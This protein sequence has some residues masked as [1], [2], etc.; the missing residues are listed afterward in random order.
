MN[1]ESYEVREWHYDP[2]SITYRGR[3]V[4]NWFSNMQSVSIKG[5]DGLTYPSVEHY[6]Q[7]HKTLDMSLRKS[8]IS[9][10]PY[11]VKR[12]AKT[13]DSFPPDWNDGIDTMWD[14]LNIKWNIPRWN[15]L[16]HSH[17]EIIVEWNNWR[18]SKWGVPIPPNYSSEGIGRNILG[19]M[20]MQIRDEVQSH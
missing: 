7:L 13:L 11:E 12:W 15:Q 17:K 20:L 14:A 5:N 19:R 16:L 10:N 8:L 1:I 6:F 2:S 9:L 3:Y 18:D 4:S